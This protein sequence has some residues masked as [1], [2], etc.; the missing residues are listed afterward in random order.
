[1]RCGWF[2]VELHV[3]GYEMV[4]G[5]RGHQRQLS[6]QHRASHDPRELLRVVAGL[7]RRHR[8]AADSYTVKC[9]D[10]SVVSR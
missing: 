1:M 10:G 8:G 7:I 2:S 4:G 6:G 9:E 5:Q 3:C